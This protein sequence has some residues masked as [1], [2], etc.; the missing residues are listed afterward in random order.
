MSDDTR[1]DDTQRGDTPEA[2]PGT[3]STPETQQAGTPAPP[4][5]RSRVLIGLAVVV[6]FAVIIGVRLFDDQPATQPVNG[7]PGAP[8]AVDPVEAYDQALAGDLPIVVFFHSGGCPPCIETAEAV[9]AVM[10]GYAD[11]VAYVDAPTGDSRTRPLF[12]RLSFQFVP[13]TFFLTPDGAVFDQF[14]GAMAAGEFQTR[15]DALVAASE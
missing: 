8:A 10:P 7:E 14:T 9:N 1:H 2:Q 4:N 15:L 11:T 6:L 12:Q 13:T 5:T 3:P